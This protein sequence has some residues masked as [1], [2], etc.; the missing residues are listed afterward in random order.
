MR[1]SHRSRIGFARRTTCV[2]PPVPSARA[3]AGR[4]GLRRK[5]DARA[6]QPFSSN[7]I[8]AALQRLAVRD[9]DDLHI[10][11]EAYDAL[12]QVARERP[13]CRLPAARAGEEDLLDLIPA[14]ELDDGGGD[15]LTA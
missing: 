2:T 12:N 13:R 14:R 15:R 4:R 9:D 8:F 11:R 3:N 7:A 10:F 6:R 1:S 5:S